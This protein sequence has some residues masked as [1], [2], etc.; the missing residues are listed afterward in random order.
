MFVCLLINQ[1]TY[2]YRQEEQGCHK[3]LLLLL[4]VPV[5]VRVPSGSLRGSGGTKPFLFLVLFHGTV[6]AWYGT[7]A[8]V[9]PG[10]DTYC[11][12]AIIEVIEAILAILCCFVC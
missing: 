2:I 9:R 8:V 10:T 11:N 7:D 1:C 4:P 12:Y 6:H 5:P 3:I